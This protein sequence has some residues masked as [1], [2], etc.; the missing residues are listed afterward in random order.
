MNSFSISFCGNI[1]S[2]Q[3]KYFVNDAF[4]GIRLAWFNYFET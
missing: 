1:Y 4:V 3:A 2:R